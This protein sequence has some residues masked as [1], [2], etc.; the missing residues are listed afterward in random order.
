ML[1]QVRSPEKVAPQKN[2][3]IVKSD[4]F[5]AQVITSDQIMISIKQLIQSCF[6]VDQNEN[7]CRALKNYLRGK[8][9]L[10]PLLAF[11]KLNRS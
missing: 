4:V 8:M 6:H 7:H 1:Y 9:Q 5:S 11:P 3:T 10:S 2:L